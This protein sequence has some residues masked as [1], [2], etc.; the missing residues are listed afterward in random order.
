M[1]QAGDQL[2]SIQAPHCEPFHPMHRAM[3]MFVFENFE[4]VSL[5]IGGM[6]LQPRHDVVF[7]PIIGPETRHG[8]IVVSLKR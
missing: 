3:Q 6:H 2:V 7:I 8:Y 1:Q 5:V 4:E